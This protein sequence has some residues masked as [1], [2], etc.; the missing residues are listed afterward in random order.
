MSAHLF[1]LERIPIEASEEGVRGDGGE[2]GTKARLGVVGDEFSEEG[3][4]DAGAELGAELDL[5]AR[6]E[7]HERSHVK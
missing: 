1:A 2:V 7:L 4:E 3:L 6:D 5:A